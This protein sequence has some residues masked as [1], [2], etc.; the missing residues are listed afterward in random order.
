MDQK[1]K[2]FEEEIQLRGDSVTKIQVNILF[3]VQ[4]FICFRDI[5]L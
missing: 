3:T 1:I 4:N 5:Q 2:N